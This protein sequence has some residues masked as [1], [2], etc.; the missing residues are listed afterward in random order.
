[1]VVF[2]RTK[3]ET[4]DHVDDWMEE[5]QRYEQ[6]NTIKLLVGNKSDMAE[7]VSLSEARRKADQLSIAYM[8]T[9]A[10]TGY[11]VDAAFTKLARLLMQQREAEGISQGK[12]LSTRIVLEKE[13]KQIACCT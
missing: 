11:Q 3:A 6:Q 8:E 9:S 5:V 1:M 2:D 10:K 4:F 13:N 7:G 12:G